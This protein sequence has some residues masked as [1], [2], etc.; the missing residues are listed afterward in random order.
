MVDIDPI[1]ISIM[2]DIDPTRISIM[3]DIDLTL[4]SIMVEMNTLNRNRFDNLNLNQYVK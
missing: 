3:V 2:V 1:L 4:I